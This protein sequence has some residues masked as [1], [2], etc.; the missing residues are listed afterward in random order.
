AGR[1]DEVELV[2]LVRDDGLEVLM[3]VDR[4]A[5]G[6]GDLLAEVMGRDESN[7]RFTVSSDSLGNLGSMIGELIEANA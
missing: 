2:P 3:Q 5:R 6:L 7:L 1:R 4:K